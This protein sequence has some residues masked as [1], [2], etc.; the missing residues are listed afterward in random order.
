[1][2]N[3]VT[4]YTCIMAFN[5]NVSY[6]VFRKYLFLNLHFKN[7]ITLLKVMVLMTIKQSL[8]IFFMREQWLLS[9]PALTSDYYGRLSAKENFSLKNACKVL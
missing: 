9:T 3:K 7:K 8:Y 1:M 2:N 4:I 5:L 6:L